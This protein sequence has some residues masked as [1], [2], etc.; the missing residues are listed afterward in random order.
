LAVAAC[1]S[2]GA[3]APDPH[4]WRVAPWVDVNSG[5]ETGA[6]V[7]PLLG[8]EAIPGGPFLGFAPSV[9]IGKNLGRRNSLEILANGSVE[10]FFE[11]DGRTLMGLSSWVE[12]DFRSTG[13]L[14]GRVA[15]GLEYFDDTGLE[16]AERSG[17]G[18]RLALGLQGSR[19]GAEL[20]GG[21]RGRRYP[22]PTTEDSSE[23]PGT[24]TETLGSFGLSAWRSGRRWLI[25]GELGRQVNDSSDPTF[26]TV[27]WLLRAGLRLSVGRNWATWLSGSYQPREYEALEA[28]QNEDSYLQ[29][30]LRVTRSLGARQTTGVAYSYVRYV[31]VLDQ[32]DDSHRVSVLYTYRFGGPAR[33]ASSGWAATQGRDEDPAVRDGIV[34]FRLLAPEAEQVQVVGDFN[35][36]TAGAHVLSRRSGGWWETTLE[37]APGSY[38]FIYLVD[39]EAT[40]PPQAASWVDDGF[41]G[42]NGFFTVPQP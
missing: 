15:A 23:A 12:F 16:T 7:D 24:Y 29:A 14:Y 11:D 31:D 2:A 5:Y 36:W 21:V 35:G 38:Q 4:A 9:V 40:L 42:K 19:G 39:G 22:N 30:G 26:D 17:V 1:S 28:G 18:G 20:E 6:I 25:Q 34:R 32:D 41:G 33:G 27:S 8:R 10:R 3:Q 13:R 37:L